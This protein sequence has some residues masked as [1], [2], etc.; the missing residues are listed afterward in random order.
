MTVGD[1]LLVGG[2]LK[3]GAVTNTADLTHFQ[4]ADQAGLT[5][6]HESI[7][8]SSALSKGAAEAA[9]PIHNGDVV[10]IRQLPGW[11]DLGASI[12]VKGE[13]KHAGT[14]GIRPGERLSSILE[15]AG[16]FQP[17]AYPYGAVL[18]RVQV[19]ELEAKQQ[20][21]LILRVKD[22]ERDLELLPDSDPKQKQDKEA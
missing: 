20:D 7:S 22:S 15:R 5:A 11:N 18:Q 1:L 10:T 16:G 6:Q 14:F 13:V 9:I 17:G 2:G 3:P 4:Y 19:R 12:S 21:E 8:I